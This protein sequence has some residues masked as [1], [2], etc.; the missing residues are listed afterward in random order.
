MK[1]IVVL[2]DGMADEPLEALGGKTPLEYAHTPSMD[3]LA[4]E[5]ALMLRKEPARTSA[6]T[7]TATRAP[8]NTLPLRPTAEGL[9]KQSRRRRFLTWS[10]LTLQRGAARFL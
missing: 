5:G 1:Y 6:R 4:R 3:R 10:S 2:G 9:Q 7:P 8:S